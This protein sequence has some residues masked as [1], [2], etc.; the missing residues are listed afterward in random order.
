MADGSCHGRLLPQCEKLFWFSSLT[1]WP[2]RKF[3]FQTEF[4]ELC[5]IFRAQIV[6]LNSVNL[7]FQ[8][9][10]KSEA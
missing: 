10:K 5:R 4:T 2:A 6:K 7:V 3:F 8:E 1:E 9:N